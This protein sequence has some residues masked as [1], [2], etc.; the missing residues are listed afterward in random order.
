MTIRTASCTC[1]Q[2]AAT[3]RAEPVRVSVCHCLAC[4]RRSGSAFEVQAQFPADAVKVSGRSTAYVRI[5]DGGG[6]ARFHFCPVCGDS[7]YYVPEARPGLVALPVGAFAGPG[8]PPPTV[9]VYEERRHPRVGLPD[10][11]ARIA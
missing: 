3:V 1:G 2:L 11:I 6:R 5:G 4:Q 10:G 8:F 9:P 7:V